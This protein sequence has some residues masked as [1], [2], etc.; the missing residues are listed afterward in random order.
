MILTGVANVESVVYSFRGMPDGSE[1]YAGLINIG[2]ILYGTTLGGGAYADAIN[3]TSGC[4]TVFAVEPTTGGE[5]VLHSFD[6][7]SG[8]GAEPFAGLTNV[9]GT[10]YGATIGGGAYLVGTVFAIRP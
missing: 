10:I 1:P 2:G 4:G 6:L 5:V 7:D 9:G 8:D 3:C